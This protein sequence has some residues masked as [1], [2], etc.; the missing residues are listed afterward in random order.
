MAAPTQTPHEQ[1]LHLDPTV[2]DAPYARDQS[3]DGFK[4]KTISFMGR[5]VPILLQNEFG[6]CALLGIANALLLRNEISLSTDYGSVNVET[7]IS[8]L[9]NRLLEANNEAVARADDWGVQL[10]KSLDEAIALLP[11]FKQGLDVN[12][13]FSG[14]FE[15]TQGLAVF[16]L[17]NLDLVHGWMPE[18][19]SEAQRL[20]EGL[21]YN[22]VIEKVVEAR[23]A[24][25][26]DYDAEVAADFL[27][28]TASQLTFHGLTTLHAR[29]RDRGLAVLYRN[30]HFSTIIKYGDAIYALVTDLGYHTEPHVVWEKLDDCDGDTEYVDADFV[31]R[32]R[33]EAS[34]SHQ[35]EDLDYLV[36]LQL[37]HDA[38]SE[39]LADPSVP[40]ARLETHDSDYQAALQLQLEMDQ[41]L[42]QQQQL[43]H[44]NPTH[45][46]LRHT[47]R[48]SDDHTANR[49]SNCVLL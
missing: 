15:Y 12:V 35:P 30:L 32:P 1:A 21:G 37:Q 49:A 5:S 43:Q 46:S 17:L 29:L 27:E 14:S 40:P 25:S 48:D 2:A 44:R 18:P 36:A 24:A 19:G 4:V 33:E 3:F 13:R 26:H 10:S 47:R 42:S 45:Q 20:L 34:P 41:E 22:Q 6:P 7:V 39:S 8:L 31:I 23:A 11:E 28:K 9:A 16:D 38:G